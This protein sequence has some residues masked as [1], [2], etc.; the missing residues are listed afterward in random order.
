MKNTDTLD[1]TGQVAIITGAGRGLGR[2]HALLLASRGCKVLINDLGGA[3][4]GRGG[5]ESKVADAVVEEIKA[6]GG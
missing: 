1:F 3:Y 5:V 2:Q 4:D 6:A